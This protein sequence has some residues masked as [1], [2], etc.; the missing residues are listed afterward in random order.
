M[1]ERDGC[2]LR[3]GRARWLVTLLAA[4]PLVFVQTHSGADSPGLQLVS[5]GL[6]ASPCGSGDSIATAL[7]TALQAYAR[8][9]IATA[10]SW[11]ALASK[12]LANA[13]RTQ[14]SPSPYLVGN[15]SQL[16][17][18]LQ[19]YRIYAA[20]SRPELDAQYAAL[21]PQLEDLDL[22]NRDAL[23]PDHL[24]PDAVEYHLITHLVTRLGDVAVDY[25]L[26]THQIT[27]LGDVRIDYKLNT[28][29]PEKIGGIEF[30]YDLIDGR[31]TKVAGVEVR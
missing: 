18:M 24:G 5:P 20:G 2:R 28:G 13:A 8:G 14:P 3:G 11:A 10:R 16:R 19:L 26:I 7:C 17:E 12:Q 6:V 4:G 30:D 23:R 29:M 25:H 21:V 27:R 9:E 15:A 22:L 31:V 1:F